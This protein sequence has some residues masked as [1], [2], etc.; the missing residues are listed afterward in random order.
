MP[1]ILGL[2]ATDAG[3]ALVGGHGYPDL[4]LTCP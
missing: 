4:S 3:H 1:V 2:D